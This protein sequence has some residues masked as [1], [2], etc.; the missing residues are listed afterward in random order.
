MSFTLNRLKSD[1]TDA[2]DILTAFSVDLLDVVLCLSVVYYFCILKS[3]TAMTK[4]VVCPFR[5]SASIILDNPQT[6][7][8]TYERC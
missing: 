6:S 1:G 4:N 8:S 3:H 2:S 5:S 7:L